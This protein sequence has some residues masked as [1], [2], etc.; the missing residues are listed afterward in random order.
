MPKLILI[1]DRA[2]DEAVHQRLVAAAPE[3]DDDVVDRGGEARVSDQGKPE[4]V[5]L[6]PINVVT[7]SRSARASVG[8]A[9]SF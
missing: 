8:I 4:R 5:P 1:D 6:A 9:T 7:V 3:L 2:I